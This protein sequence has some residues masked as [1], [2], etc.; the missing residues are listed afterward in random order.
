ML[1]VPEDIDN[2]G[3]HPRV[4]KK[5]KMSLQKS[6]PILGPNSDLTF[7]Q[8]PLASDRFCIHSFAMDLS[9]IGELMALRDD[10]LQTQVKVEPL[11]AVPKLQ[12]VLRTDRKA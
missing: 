2:V 1:L 3:L 11:E 10:T 4:C 7:V 6:K 5:Q 9:V 8:H 12:D